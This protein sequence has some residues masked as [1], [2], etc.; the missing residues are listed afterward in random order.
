GIA[1][2]PAIVNSHVSAIGPAQLLQRLQECRNVALRAR[3]VP[4]AAAL[5]HCDVPHPLGLL[6]TRRERP[7][8]CAAHQRDELAPFH[9]ITSSA[10]TSNDDGTSMPSCLA[11][12]ALITSSYLVGACTG[13]S[14]GFSPLRMRSTYPAAR[15]YWSAKSGP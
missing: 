11:V 8:N 3:I 2:R 6:R 5:N 7:R 9:S 1:H 4:V 10:R 12:L 15:R 13:R 14:A